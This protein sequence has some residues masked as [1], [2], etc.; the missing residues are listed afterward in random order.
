MHDLLLQQEWPG[1]PAVA[2]RYSGEAE[3]EAWACKMSC[4]NTHLIASAV[5]TTQTEEEDKVRRTMKSL[6][7]NHVAN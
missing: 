7:P 6:D 3:L 1:H 2:S 5:C 4:S